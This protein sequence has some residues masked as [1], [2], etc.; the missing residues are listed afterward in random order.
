LASKAFL[1]IS[2][3]VDVT[4]R[5]KLLKQGVSED[6]IFEPAKKLDITHQIEDFYAQRPILLRD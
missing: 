5:S 6:N 2:E 1:L 3:A 4:N